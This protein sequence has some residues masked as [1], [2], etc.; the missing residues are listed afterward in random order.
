M[1]AARSPADD[2]AL[3]LTNY[4]GASSTVRTAEGKPVS[5]VSVLGR[6]IGGLGDRLWQA[7]GRGGWR[8]PEWPDAPMLRLIPALAGLIVAAL[9]VL[10]GGLYVLARQADDH[11][12]AGHH[13]A[14]AGAVDALQSAS[15]GFNGI[16]PEFARVLERASGLKDLRFEAEPAEGGRE[17]QSM[18]D[19]KGRIVGWLSWEP[20]W[21]VTD[22]ILPVLPFAVLIA[23]GLAGFAT[24]VT[25][26]VGRLL[27]KLAHSEQHAQKLQYEDVLTGLPNHGHFFAAFDRACTTRHGQE[28]VAFAALDLD[29]FDEINDAVGYAGGDEVLAEVGRRLRG[30]VSP[31]SAMVA[32]L[33]S[34]EFALMIT[35]RNADSALFVAD[36]LR[37]A[38]A[39]PIL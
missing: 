28:L 8:H 21:P 11:N 2:Q 36:T 18:L 15:P 22:L 23:L 19:R 35:G 10:A 27:R 20:Q 24:L 6:R 14:L 38:L 30:A 37:Q 5:K 1:A 9:L 33:G 31:A 32:R 25:A 12:E 29:G 16:A 34:D 7:I 26:R 17:V 13:K 4:V 39:R 3:T